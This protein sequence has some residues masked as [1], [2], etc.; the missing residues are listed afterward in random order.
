MD[1]EYPCSPLTSSTGFTPLMHLVM[2]ARANH[3]SLGAITE[4]IKLDPLSINKQN[5]KGWTAL[6]LAC[7]NS[8]TFSTNE[9]V[10]LLLEMGADPNKCEETGWNALMLIS[11]YTRTDSSIEIVRLLID[12]KT[13]LN[14]QNNKGWGALTFACIYSNS[15]SSNETVEMLINAGA[16]VNIKTRKG[17]TILMLLCAKKLVDYVVTIQ[18]LIDNGIDL[19]IMD[20]NKKTIWDHFNKNNRDICI[21]ALL[22]KNTTHT[23]KRI[24]YKYTLR[25]I[26][27][28]NQTVR[29]DPTNI[30]Y[31]ITELNFKLKNGSNIYD[32]LDP[33]IADYLSVKDPEDLVDKIAQYLTQ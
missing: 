20:N 15:S 21:T 1:I 16:N 27:L 29:F 4:L 12:A 33:N 26:P 28:H 13:N 14:T 30:G 22:N 7:R 5:T 17:N 10:K 31:K 23:I 32:D 9:T 2:T 11:L 3:D 25:H 19:D 24:N 6:M 8:Q 18:I